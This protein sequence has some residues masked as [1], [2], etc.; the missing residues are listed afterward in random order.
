VGSWKLTAAKTLRAN[1]EVVF[2][3]GKN[4]IGLLMYDE[5][6]NMSGHVSR[7]R[8]EA[9]KIDDLRKGTVQEMSSAIKSYLAYFGSYTINEKGRYVTHHVT[10]S[11]FPNW[12]G[13][14]Q[15]RFYKLTGD[16]LELSAPFTLD[17]QTHTALLI[18]KR[19]T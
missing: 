12:I 14:R 17:G 15:K 18:W 7:R 19:I 13:S 8:R 9:Y 4:P 5:F 3:Y 11:L 16:T 1:G 2:P 6:G 10:G